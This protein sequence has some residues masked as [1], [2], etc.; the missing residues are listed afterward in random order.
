MISCCVFYIAKVKKKKKACLIKYA[1]KLQSLYLRFE[2]HVY[3][4]AL[5]TT[6]PPP[7]SL[8]FERL[9]WLFQPCHTRGG[10]CAW[11]CPFGAVIEADRM[12]CV[13]VIGRLWHKK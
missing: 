5:N 3:A 13:G 8:G 10:A 11:T 7:M 2:I 1:I 6:P 9:D 12:A 4:N